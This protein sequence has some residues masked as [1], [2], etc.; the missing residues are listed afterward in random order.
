MKLSNKAKTYLTMVLVVLLFICYGAYP[1]T[2]ITQE[3]STTDVVDLDKSG[4][5]LL[6]DGTTANCDYSVLYLIKDSVPKTITVITHVRNF[7]CWNTT[8]AYIK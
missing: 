6:S 5:I 4:Y 1:R 7:R 2:T 8:F 3:Y